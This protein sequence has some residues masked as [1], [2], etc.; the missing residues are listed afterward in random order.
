M[1]SKSGRNH[2]NLEM[3]SMGCFCSRPR[4]WKPFQFHTAN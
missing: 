3:Y 1:T 2:Q 4:E